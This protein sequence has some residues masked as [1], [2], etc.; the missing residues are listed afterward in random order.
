M[1][2]TIYILLAFLFIERISNESILIC[3]VQKTNTINLC[4][5]IGSWTFWS[6]LMLSE[7]V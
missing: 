4:I 5:L 7:T 1:Q 6:Q 3:I 2:L